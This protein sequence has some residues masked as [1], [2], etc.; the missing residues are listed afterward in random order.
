M[1]AEKLNESVDEQPDMVLVDSKSAAQMAAY[2]EVADAC[3]ERMQKAAI[4]I[5]ELRGVVGGFGA[6]ET[7]I[8]E[9]IVP[10]VHARLEDEENPLEKE[11]IKEIV[12]YLIKAMKLM[13]DS[14]ISNQ[15]VLNTKRSEVD[16]LQS[17]TQVCEALFEKIKQKNLQRKNEAERGDTDEG[18]RPLPVREI[19]GVDE[20][21][22]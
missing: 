1:E 19:A 10:Q 2:Q 6:A 11:T 18:G 5:H 12:Q 7:L 21:D 16:G 9:K 8:R 13:N 17:A 14:R 20:N 22:E 3:G 15:Q 4:A